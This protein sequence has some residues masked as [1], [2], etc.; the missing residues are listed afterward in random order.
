MKSSSLPI[1]S[2]DFIEWR[3]KHSFQQNLWFT[4]FWLF[5]YTKAKTPFGLASQCLSSV[6]YWSKSSPTSHY[7]TNHSFLIP[8]N[9]MTQIL[10]S[11]FASIIILQKSLESLYCWNPYARKKHRQGICIILPY[12]QTT[13]LSMVLFCT[14]MLLKTIQEKAKIWYVKVTDQ[15]QCESVRQQQKV[16]GFF[17]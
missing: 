7:K 11:A 13:W 1:V 2:P 6:L 15:W 8:N 4:Y 16:K 14:L 17:I 9:R 3:W 5:Y 10:V 12:F